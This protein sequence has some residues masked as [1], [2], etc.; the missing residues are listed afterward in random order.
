VPEELLAGAAGGQRA[1]ALRGVA[2]QPGGLRA[3]GRGFGVIVLVDVRCAAEVVV[4]SA[5]VEVAAV[6]QQRSQR[7]REGRRGARRG[8]LL[9]LLA[10]AP[11]AGGAVVV[12]GAGGGEGLLQELCYVDGAA[13]V[14]RQRPV[15]RVE[16][17]A[18]Q[19]EAAG[20]GGRG[21]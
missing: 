7:Q 9:G 5:G 3:R 8:A 2:Q 18:A 19:G 4:V 16:A 1:R 17:G 12:V 13:A 11:L 10:A 6:G 20:V 21:G 14:Q 15:R